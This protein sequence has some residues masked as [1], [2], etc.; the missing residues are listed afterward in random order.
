MYYSQTLWHSDGRLHGLKPW[1]Q[2]SNTAFVDW[3]TDREPALPVNTVM[4]GC[5]SDRL[6]QQNPKKYNEAVAAVWPETPMTQYFNSKQ[7]E[8]IERFLSLY[9]DHP[10]HLVRVIQDT[11]SA[12]G[13]P[14]WLFQYYESNT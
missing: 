13:Y 12:T 1:P 6:F 14:L 9:F 8:D 3:E 4:K 7:A 11:N 2:L 5:Y 10:V